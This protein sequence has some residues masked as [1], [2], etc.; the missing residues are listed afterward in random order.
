VTK[1]KNHARARHG[2]GTIREEMRT[3]LAIVATVSGLQGLVSK[4]PTTPVC[5]PSKPCTA[6]AQVTLLFRRTGVAGTARTYR[7]RSGADGR[8][9][10][11]LSPGYYSVTTLERIGI[12]RNIR[13]RAVHV[14]VGHVDRLDFS[15]DTG[16]R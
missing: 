16:I 11:S 7:A 6:P 2:S 5:R 8:Y 12:T 3:F 10:I 9:R 15:I 14:R 4:G 13:P 1:V